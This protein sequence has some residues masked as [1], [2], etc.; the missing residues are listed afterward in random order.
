MNYIK[1]HRL[2]PNDDLHIQEDYIFFDTETNETFLN[3]DIRQHTL[4]L[5]WA[6]YWNKK[7]NVEEWFNFIDKKIFWDFVEKK[8]MNI[9]ELII[10]AHN[11]DFDF[12]IVDGIRQLTKRRYKLHRF[13]ING[14]VFSLTF[15]KK[16]KT[17]RIYDT[18]N[19]V[20]FPLKKI[21]E[22]LGCKKL[23]IEFNSCT[24]DELS[25]YCKNDVKIIYLFIKKL[26]DFLETNNLCRL[27]PTTSSIA[28]N[29]FRHR[30]YDYDNNP[31]YIHSM[32]GAIE[33]ERKSYH[34][35]ITD[36]FKVGKFKDK[37]VKLDINSMYPYQMLINEL[38]TKLIYY[39]DKKED[40]L[41]EKLFT[42][43]KK[44]HI[45]ADC[46]IF[47]PKEYAYILT[48]FKVN[49]IEKNGFIYGKFRSVLSTPEIEFVLKYGKI[50]N[51]NKLYVYKKSFI[52]KDYVNF[53][54]KKRFEYKNDGN[55]IFE[56][57]CKICLNGLYGKF[58]QK[59]SMYKILKENIEYDVGKYTVLLDEKGIVKEC[60]VMHIGNKI[61]KVSYLDNNA[62]DSFVAISSMITA[63]ARMYLIELILKVGR[64]NVYY[65]D[66]DSLIIKKSSLN[67]LNKYINN[68]EIGKLKIEG[69][70]NKSEFIRPKWYTFNN[71]EK[72]KGVKKSH[73][74]LYDN[75]NER[76]IKQDQWERFKTS[77]RNKNVDKQMIYPL[78]KTLSK[79][80]DKGIVDKDGNVLPYFSENI[81][82]II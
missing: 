10:F 40:N 19:Y 37:L 70:S 6:L 76:K 16:K 15:K 33:I 65:V 80:Y 66:T 7:D 59:S 8:I 73:I 41:K 82:L 57:F 34:G 1:T 20:P 48:K 11:T 81:E 26:L 31:I 72:C 32:E 68:N 18:M 77:I 3:D 75:N 13:Y 35:G 24:N 62:Y 69:Y 38:P 14:S 25:I 42:L 28:L 58:A 64:E 43:I 12:K 47:L 30:F 51:V 61:V 53:F 63:Y 54:Y 67:K 9:S 4:K 60:L 71:D 74:V 23:N 44:H 39:S 52:F 49:K 36:C 2:K 55:Y 56:H 45:I 5:G 17:I 21:G 46:K 78:E 29:A 22:I 50:I 79:K 27:R